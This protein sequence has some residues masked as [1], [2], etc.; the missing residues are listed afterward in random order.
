MY[1]AKRNVAFRGL[2]SAMKKYSVKP[3]TRTMNRLRT[4][5]KVAPN[6]VQARKVLATF[7]SKRAPTKRASTNRKML[8]GYMRRRYYSS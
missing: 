3:H 1:H 6:R 2:T 8:T 4:H 5:L 7:L